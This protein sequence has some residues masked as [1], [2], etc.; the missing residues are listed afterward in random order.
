MKHLLFYIRR[1]WQILNQKEKERR[2]D[3]NPTR[4]EVEMIQINETLWF[5]KWASRTLT[6]ETKLWWRRWWLLV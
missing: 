3:L 4:G 2:I 6:H 5:L 1:E